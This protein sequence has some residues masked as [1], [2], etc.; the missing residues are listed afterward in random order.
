ML[1]QEKE[2]IKEKNFWIVS[3]EILK[4]DVYNDNHKE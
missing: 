1:V 4:I 3:S 2:R